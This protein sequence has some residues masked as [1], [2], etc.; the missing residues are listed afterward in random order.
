MPLTRYLDIAEPVYQH[1]PGWKGHDLTSIRSWQDLPATARQY[2]ER[3]ELLL[4]TPVRMISV[5]P[6]RDALIHRS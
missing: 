5:G 4:E 1:M 2:V 3:I 6:H